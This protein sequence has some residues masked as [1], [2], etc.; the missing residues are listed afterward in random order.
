M[1]EKRL[2]EK[3]VSIRKDSGENNDMTYSFLPRTVIESLTFYS[4]LITVFK[5]Y[6]K[7]KKIKL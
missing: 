1:C 4:N 3:R 5:L 7:K 2:N 6:K